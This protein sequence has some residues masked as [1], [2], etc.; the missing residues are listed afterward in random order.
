MKQVCRVCMH[1]C[2]LNPGQTGICKARKNEE[3]K[4][5]CVNYGQITSM[6]LDPI[7]KKCSS[8]LGFRQDYKFRML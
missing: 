2:N 7:E 4:I 3:G 6:A 5:V 1:Q 8:L